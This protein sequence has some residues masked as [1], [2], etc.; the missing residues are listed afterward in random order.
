MTGEQGSSAIKA[1]R[2]FGHRFGER[3]RWTREP[4]R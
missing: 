2:G 1:V 3:Y 4:G